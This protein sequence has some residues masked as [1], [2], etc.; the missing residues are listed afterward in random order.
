MTLHVVASVGWLGAIAA[1]LVLTVQRQLA[2][3]VTLQTELIP[4]LAVVMGSPTI[5]RA[6]IVSTQARL[7]QET[8]T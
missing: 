1:S 8:P 7:R 6:G 2:A 4:I 3:A 5:R